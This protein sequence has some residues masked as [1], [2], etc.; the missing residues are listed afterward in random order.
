MRWL[1]VLLTS[2]LLSATATPA[3]P[4]PPPEGFS[5]IRKSRDI[6]EYRLDSNGLTVLLQPQPSSP[7]VTFMVTYLI[8]SRNES[9]GATGATHLLEHL[10]F[11]GT[12]KHNKEAGTG[13]DQLLEATGAETNATTWLDRTNYFTTLAPQHLPLIITLEADRMRNLRLREEDR[14]P[15]MT[16]V[17]NEFQIAENDPGTTLQTEIW[18]TAFQAHPYRHSVLG[19]L[20]DVENVSIETLRH[21]YNTYYWPNNAVVSIVGNFNP[22]DALNLVRQ[23]YGP[24]PKSPSTIPSVHTLEP[25]QT[26]PRRITLKRPGELG[27]FSIAYKIPP[28][29][30][31]D[32]PALTVL[33]DLLADGLRC[34]FYLELTDAGLTTDVIAYP[35]LT[36]DPSL[37]LITAELAGDS[38][39]EEVE[40]KLLSVLSEVRQ[41]G[42]TDK[43]IQHAIARLNAQSAFSRDGSTT[44]SESLTEAIAVGDWTLYHTWDDSIA[45]VTPADV[46]RVANQYLN[47]DQSTTGLFIPTN[48]PATETTAAS[49]PPKPNKPTTTASPLILPK[50]PPIVTDQDTKISS[51][52][53]RT[54]TAGIDLLVCPTA[55]K[56]TATIVCTI[57]LGP[58]KNP[59]LPSF[60]AAMLEYGT[61]LKDVEELTNI[62]DSTGAHMEFSIEDGALTAFARCLK[63]DL[64]TVI[65]LLSE[66][67]RLPLFHREDIQFLREQLISETTSGTTDTDVQAAVAFSREAFPQGHPNRQPSPEEA[68]AAIK[69]I[70]RKDLVDFHKQWVGP[71]AATL[72]ITGDVDPASCQNQVES[73]FKNWQG[74]Q[75]PPLSPP[76]PKPTS[77]TK[78]IVTI[79][80]KESVSIILGQ[81]TGLTYRDP[82]SLPL[83][84]ATAALGQGFTSRLLSTV[85]DVE[86]LTYGIQAGLLGNTATDGSWQIT[87]SFAP[88]SLTQGMSSIRRELEKWH[89]HGLTA[90][91]LAYHQSALAGNHRLNLAS[92]ENLA[93]ALSTTIRR[94]LDPEWLDLYPAKVAAVTLDQVN[95]S[96]RRLIDP[97]NSIII[98]AGS[99]PTENKTPKNP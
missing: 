13:I 86:G 69:S 17:R 38:T 26:G 31:P 49:P 90:D 24:I 3:S 63:K 39:H 66:Q 60:M 9:Y 23:H 95:T 41:N 15:E 59:I 75:T 27:L 40:T 6:T 81:P 74:G 48:P 35:E 67:L 32:S 84:I 18:A 71:T 45:K 34:R 20:S 70:R 29:T 64:P 33:S 5:E 47:T 88:D 72:V 96:I 11:K 1:N 93:L 78:R 8:G 36:R 89:T 97:A 2:L 73:A 37:F 7:V 77:P 19:W 14:Q 80:G 44:I 43:E 87:A 57:P 68:L 98:Q 94:G 50:A 82:D 85:R 91:E 62:L 28:A 42:V 10:M 56:D 25:P 79:P 55:T 12:P 58:G 54:R 83:A 99:L 76:A 92:S 21:F 65:S 52:I 53:R 22:E 30:H 51:N 16:V 4:T 61:T 46:K